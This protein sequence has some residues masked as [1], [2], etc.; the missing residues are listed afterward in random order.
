MSKPKIEV[1]VEETKYRVRAPINDGSKVPTYIDTAVKI[2][3]DGRILVE[4]GNDV[5]G[6]SMKV[7]EALAFIDLLH[8]AIHLSEKTSKETF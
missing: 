5:F 6:R 4:R 2:E 8:Q 1:R 7:S 3:K